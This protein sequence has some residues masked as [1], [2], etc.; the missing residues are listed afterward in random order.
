MIGIWMDDEG[1]EEMMSEETLERL[2]EAAERCLC[3]EGFAGETDRMALSLTLAGEEEIREMNREYRGV[4]RVTDVLSF[5]MFD[6]EEDIR[7]ALGA[8]ADGEAGEEIPGDEAVCGGPE[9]EIPEAQI[10]LGDVVLCREKIRQQAVEY[11]HSEER[12][13]VY[14]FVHSLLHLL[15]FDHMDE[16]EKKVMREKEEAVMTAMEL[17]R[18]A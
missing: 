7:E 16:D 6:G 3:M 2:K 18:Q 11:G 8:G 5:P 14:L 9:A 15:G 12:E 17:A 1:R 10:P 13:L 4:D